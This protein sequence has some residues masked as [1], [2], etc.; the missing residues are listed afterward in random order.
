MNVKLTD[1]DVVEIRRRISEG[2]PGVIGQLSKE[3][4]VSRRTLYNIKSG[5]SWSHLVKDDGVA[6]KRL[7]VGF[8]VISSRGSDNPGAELTENEVREIRRKLVGGSWGNA[9]R[10]AK[11]YGISQSMISRIKNGKAWSHVTL[12]EEQ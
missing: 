6:E 10:L 2:T 4:H 5:R 3:Y 8:Q 11:E 9:T 12:I 1:K 7:M